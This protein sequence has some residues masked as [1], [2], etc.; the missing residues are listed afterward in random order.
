MNKEETSFHL[1]RI[2]IAK[3]NERSMVWKKT[4]ATKA[5]HMT[6]A[7]RELGNISII[8]WSNKHC[9]QKKHWP[10]AVF[11]VSLYRIERMEASL[12]MQKMYCRRADLCFLAASG[13]AAHK[14]AAPPQG[15]WVVHNLDLLHWASFCSYKRSAALHAAWLSWSGHSLGM[16]KQYIRFFGLICSYFTMM[17]ASLFLFLLVDCQ[18][19]GVILLVSLLL[20]L[21]PLRRCFS[22]RDWGVLFCSLLLYRCLEVQAV[23]YHKGPSCKVLFGTSWSEWKWCPA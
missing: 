20:F 10:K 17:D 14:A 5:V 6:S 11:L 4:L 21:C 13:C 19:V 9:W 23:L 15:G 3:D 7:M 1:A 12:F 18:N 16:L 2:A 22:K 8:R